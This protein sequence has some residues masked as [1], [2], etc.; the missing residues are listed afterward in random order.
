MKKTKI[1][2]VVAI[3]V[4]SI[5]LFITTNLLFGNKFKSGSCIKDNRDGYIWHINDY[6][7]GKYYLMGWQDNGWGHPVGNKDTLERKD[8]RDGIQIYNQTACPEYTPNY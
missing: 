6:S 7:F 2:Y 1:K 8:Y 4:V 5:G 3:I